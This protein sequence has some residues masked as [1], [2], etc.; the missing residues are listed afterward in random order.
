MVL[1]Q[2]RSTLL[3]HARGRMRAGDDMLMLS[4]VRVK[5][6]EAGLDH[7][8]GMLQRSIRMQAAGTGSRQRRLVDGKCNGA[9]MGPLVT[10]ARARDSLADLLSNRTD[11][12]LDGF[13][14]G[15][16]RLLASKTEVAPREPAARASSQRPAASGQRPA[17]LRPHQLVTAVSGHMQRRL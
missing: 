7:Q 17:L 11:S 3:A 10:R 9:Q 13:H 8:G 14:A 12:G 1:Q 4:V 5:L 15:S 2:Y 6:R 16:I